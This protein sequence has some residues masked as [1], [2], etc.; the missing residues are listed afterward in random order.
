MAKSQSIL[1]RKRD[2]SKIRPSGEGPID[3]SQK[4]YQLRNPMADQ[5]LYPNGFGIAGDEGIYQAGGTVQVIDE[6]VINGKK[7]YLIDGDTVKAQK[8]TKVK[9]IEVYPTDPE[10][11]AK[12]KAYQDSLKTYNYY[13]DAYENYPDIKRDNLKYEDAIKGSE[14]GKKFYLEK[15][16]FSKEPIIAT[17]KPVQPYFI[18]KP[19]GENTFIQLRYDEQGNEFADGGSVT[20]TT[21][22]EKHKVY[23]KKSP[24]GMGKGKEGHIMVNHPTKDKGKWDTIDLTQIAGAKTVAEG[25]AATKKW[26]KEN[27]YKKA[28][29]GIIEDNR[30]QWAYPGEVTKINSPYITMY[31]VP[32]PVL[33]VSDTGDQQLMMP[34]QDYSYDGNSVTEYPLIAQD[35]IIASI[36]RLFGFAEAGK[37]KQKVQ[38]LPEYVNIED[39]RKVNPVTGKPIDPNRELKSGKY[40][41]KIIKDIVDAANKLEYKHPYRAIAVGLQESNLGKT[42]ENLGHVIGTIPQMDL[43]DAGYSESEIDS[44]MNVNPNYASAVNMISNLRNKEAEAIR[45]GYKTP[46]YQLQFYNGMGKLT[47]ATEKAYHNKTGRNTNQFYGVDVTKQPLDLAKNPAY[48]KTVMSLIP[49]L[50]QNPDIQKLVKNTKAKGGKIKVL[51]EKTI[52]GKKQYLIDTKD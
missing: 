29:G 23:K 22:G 44:I 19:E 32:Y 39:T 40:S 8:G 13:K 15:G 28:K 46:E 3:V 12:L 51:K 31:G 16:K 34:G 20:F 9:P 42:D 7:M 47:P 2:Q 30:G 1:G 38:Q 14:Y 43:A 18:P 24:T 35:G 21:Q 36:K 26:H 50:Q 49:I 52:N 11:M 27:P 41:A 37:P 10:G 48:G 33:G 25:V 6:K 45:K 5:K 17:K 4:G